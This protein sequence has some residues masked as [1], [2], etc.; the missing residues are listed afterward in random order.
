ML[1]KFL[2]QFVAIA[3]FV[4][5]EPC[6][7]DGIGFAVEACVDA[8]CVEADDGRFAWAGLDFINVLQQWNNDGLPLFGRQ[9][10][11]DP[12]VCANGQNARRGIPIDGAAIQIS[13]VIGIDT[14]FQHL[15]RF[16]QIF[17]L[18][19]H[20]PRE[21]AFGGLRAP[22]LYGIDRR[23]R[24]DFDRARGGFNIA[25]LDGL[26]A[27]TNRIVWIRFDFF[28]KCLV[29]R[30]FR[31]KSTGL[32]GRPCICI[33]EKTRV[34]WADFRYPGVIGGDGR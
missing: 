21:G 33:E 13:L 6:K 32:H 24:R 29:T 18:A 8:A 28:Q 5:G 2:R 16:F 30:L 22:F 31:A 4:G 1:D 34:V 9:S 17:W 11:V 14:D 19:G 26:K 15:T 10:V 3:V 27:R 12:V 7:P 20:P 23:R 25:I